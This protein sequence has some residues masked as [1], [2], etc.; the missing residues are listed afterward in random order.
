[1]RL[2]KYGYI[3]L[4]LLF[5]LAMPVSAYVDPS[6]VTTAVQVIAG[7][8]V[9]VGTLA[10]VL[11][12]RVK[13]V[14]LNRIGQDGNGK[15]EREPNVEFYDD[16][17]DDDDEDEETPIR[18]YR[19][20][21]STQNNRLVNAFGHE[22]ALEMLAQA[23]FDCVDISFFCMNRDPECVFLQPGAEDLCRKLRAKTESLGLRFNQSHA[24]FQMD[25]SRWLEGD[26]EEI[27]HL[28]NT[29]IRLSGILGVK[30]VVVHPLH[31]MN[32]LNNDPAWIKQMNVEYYSALI[33]AAK[34][35]GVKI[36]IENMWQ[37][38][39]YSNHIVPSVCASP[40]ELRDYVDTCNAV[41]PVFTACLDIGHC[42]LT[43]HDPANAIRVLGDRLGALHVHDVDGK[44]D[45]HTCPLTLCVDFPAV[46]E[47]LWEVGYQ[48]EFT[49]EADEFYNKFPKEKYG[50][51][52]QHM[53]TV[54][55]MLTTP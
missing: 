48:G 3:T 9:V 41:A 49:L 8:A 5:M 1:M 17:D 29:A 43:G 34:E 30:N 37:R 7:V 46:V 2:L 40:Y 54:S 51:A 19:I 38:N 26:R 42:V 36:G 18:R 39:R 12:R 27:L 44:N 4:C 11:W 45:S 6:V 31:C 15:K 24:P 13:K 28:L 35:A 33:P 50:V 47:A 32:Y 23:G 10:G 20:P 16:E 22:K 55:K 25:M 52:L 14:L 21:I 53:A